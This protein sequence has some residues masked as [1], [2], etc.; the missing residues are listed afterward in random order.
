LDIIEALNRKGFYA[1]TALSKF[2]V[3]LTIF[4]SASNAHAFTSLS[5]V[6]GNQIW[7]NHLIQFEGSMIKQPNEPS[8]KANHEPT[9]G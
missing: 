2:L 8:H 5:P 6:A 1:M 7:V 9:T 4:P 3:L